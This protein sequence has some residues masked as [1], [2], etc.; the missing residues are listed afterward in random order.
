VGPG[1]GPYSLGGFPAPGGAKHL[2]PD[3]LRR[4]GVY[5]Q[6]EPINEAARCG[7][8][9]GLGRVGLVAATHLIGAYWD[10]TQNERLQISQILTRHLSHLREAPVRVYSKPQLKKMQAA[11]KPTMDRIRPLISQ[12]EFARLSICRSATFQKMPARYEDLTPHEQTEAKR[13]LA[14]VGESVDASPQV[15]AL[16]IKGAAIHDHPLGDL[17]VRSPYVMKADKLHRQRI[18]G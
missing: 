18:A 8:N 13:I 15:D 17:V 9:A 1:S 12:D 5:D 7:E 11:L 10:R 16:G 2:I 6:L 14:G 4:P 3:V